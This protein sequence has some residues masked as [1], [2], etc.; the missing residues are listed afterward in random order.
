MDTST[1]KLAD[2]YLRLGGKRRAK[3]DD[4]IVSVREWEDDTP[5]A[6][7]FWQ[8]HIEPLDDKRRAEVELLL[9][10]INYP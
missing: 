7:A 2:E 4:N 10:T 3:V 6:E 5:D 9:P 8:E 1:K